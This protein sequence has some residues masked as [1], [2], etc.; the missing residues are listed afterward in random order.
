[1]NR[2]GWIVGF[3][4][5]I[6][7]LVSA[8]SEDFLRVE[9]GRV[10]KQNDPAAL[11]KGVEDVA[12]KINAITDAM[13]REMLLM[14]LW[15]QG[16]RRLGNLAETA[17]DSAA[18]QEKAQKWLQQSLRLSKSLMKTLDEQLMEIE[19]E[20]LETTKPETSTKW[21]SVAIRM[22]HTMYCDA[23]TRLGLAQLLTNE[24]ER[25]EMLTT[26]IDGFGAFTMKGYSTNPYVMDSFLG[27]GLALQKLGQ[28]EKVIELLEQVKGNT[29]ASYRQQYTFLRVRCCLDMGTVLQAEEAAEKY[30]QSRRG[31]RLTP[32]E[33]T[34]RLEQLKCLAILVKSAGAYAEKFQTR[35]NQIAKELTGLGPTWAKRVTE[36]TG[37]TYADPK[38]RFQEIQKRF[39]QKEYALVIQDCSVLLKNPE[40][41]ATNRSMALYI[42][43]CAY[44]NLK[45][46]PKV[47]RDGETF[48]RQYPSHERISDVLERT[49]TAGQLSMKSSEGDEKVTAKEFEAFCEAM[50][51]NVG[52]GE[53]GQKF[54]E[55]LAQSLLRRQAYRKGEIVLKRAVAAGG[56][57]LVRYQLVV[58][59]YKQWEN[60]AGETDGSDTSG[61]E[62]LLA[63]Q[64]ES[65]LDFLRFTNEKKLTEEQQRC[66]DV[67][68][69]IAV[70]VAQQYL[71]MEKQ[72]D[73]QAWMSELQTF[74]EFGRQSPAWIQLEIASLLNQNK[75]DEVLQRVRELLKIT[76]KESN[77]G[78]AE[79]LAAVLA[80][81]QKQRDKLRRHG[82]QSEATDITRDL[83]SIYQFLVDVIDENNKKH[84]DKDGKKDQNE[85]SLLQEKEYAIRY[86]F[87][88]ELLS[89]QQYARAVTQYEWLRDNTDKT[90]SGAI[91]EKLGTCYQK[92]KLY[93][94]AIET[95]R[96]LAKG[97]EPK[98]DEWY[99]A[100]YEL[101]HSYRLDGQ[102][103]HAQRLLDFF[104]LKYPET[105]YGDWTEKFRAL[106]GKSA[107]SKE[108]APAS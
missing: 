87:S 106:Q 6:A 92:I 52:S 24:T 63:G 99:R 53:Q 43:N 98:S 73:V 81:V 8:A 13:S 18:L 15:S 102:N 54:Y 27:Q 41:S 25:K 10:V 30:F 39:A 57:F 80:P 9:I 4:A 94:K 74:P 70:G 58:C 22:N 108:S 26:A 62:R 91:L 76:S 23:W 20:L 79:V 96:I 86:N 21:R 14:E 16:G 11:I 66:R 105:L 85:Q 12:T 71:A 69:G 65:L 68:I 61:I 35:C 97:L 7:T 46:Y 17:K 78:A 31:D 47:F 45:N 5:M 82:K 90:K 34:I 77:A 32:I 67:A 64:R 37:K 75:P 2:L 50:L 1:M 88:E 107:A 56:G 103:D 72:K 36:V 29:P 60:K 93:E 51:K 19:D 40:T 59:M 28:P 38:Q 83:C 44:W 104:L 48:I 42:R 49:L 95:W 55:A 100:W 3:V 33:V 101:I 84:N 89:L